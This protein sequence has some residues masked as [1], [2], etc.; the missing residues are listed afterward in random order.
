[1]MQKVF[2]GAGA[3]EGMTAQQYE[4]R[5]LAGVP[6]GGIVKPEGDR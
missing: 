5:L 2:R 6:C 4:Q 3:D 1:M